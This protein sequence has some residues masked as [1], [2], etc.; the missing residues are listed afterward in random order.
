MSSP[1]QQLAF[2]ARILRRSVALACA[3]MLLL[4]SS[5]NAGT[6]LQFAQTNPADVITATDTAGTTTLSTAGNVDG[7][8]VS[9]P[10]TISNFLGT[11]GLA[12][13]AFETYVGVT[14]T[15]AASTSHGSIF[16]NFSGTVEITSGIGGTGFNYVTATFAPVGAS[17]AV[18]LSGAAGGGAAALQ[19]SQ[20]PDSLVLTSSFAVFGPASSLSIPFSNVTPALSISG[21]SIASF[22]AQDAG[23]LSASIVTIIPEPSSLCLGSIAIVIGTLVYRKKR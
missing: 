21:G 14:S 5:A 13:P 9:V 19:A 17:S 11:P 23:T 1:D 4:S 2:S 6:I 7:G 20:P 8:G 22:T 16:Q 18:G 12:I 3:A 10:V 15:G